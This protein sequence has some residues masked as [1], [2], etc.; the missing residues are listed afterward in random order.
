MKRLT[1]N[2]IDLNCPV[3]NLPAKAYVQAVKHYSINEKTCILYRCTKCAVFF[4]G[5]EKESTCKDFELVG[6]NTYNTIPNYDHG[7]NLRFK[8]LNYI[9]HFTVSNL[10]VSFKIKSW[11]D[12]GSGMGYLLMYLK[13]RY[14][15][16]AAV[17][18]A[19]S[20]RDFISQRGVPAYSAFNDLPAE[21]K[22]DVISSID[23][24]YYSFEPIQLID[25]FYSHL[26]ENGYVIIRVS[27]RNFL[28]R[29]NKFFNRLPDDS[30]GDHFIG[31]NYKGIVKLF[32]DH[33][34]E[35]IASS[36]REDGKSYYSFKMKILSRIISFV[37]YITFG[38]VNLHPGVIIVFK[39]KIV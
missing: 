22:F 37:Y 29:F 26:N 9:Y 35:I 32:T 20:G 10:P 27:L 17:E 7:Y 18:L 1:A 19:Q 11:L 5:D 4:K 12:Y 23:S 33:G 30:L 24:F 16:L 2:S 15:D 28:I 8:F 34:F 31:Y 21:K 39:K 25:S 14:S 3:C 13:S 36:F 6:I 38:R